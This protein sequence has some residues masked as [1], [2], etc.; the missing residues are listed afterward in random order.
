MLKPL[1]RLKSE[2]TAKIWLYGWFDYYNLLKYH[3]SLKGKTSFEACGIDLKVEN[4]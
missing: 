3:L 2:K 4:D 1:I